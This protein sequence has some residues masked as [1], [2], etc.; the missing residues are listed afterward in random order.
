MLQTHAPFPQ[1][2]SYGLFDHERR[3]QLARILARN[4]DDGTVVISL[5]ERPDAGGNLTVPLVD[6]FD[7]T[8]LAAVEHQEMDALGRALHGK[9][10]RTKR[11]RDD[12]H[13]YEALRLRHIHADLLA[14]KLREDEQRLRARRKVA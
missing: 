4:S 14:D 13:R 5:P 10:V 11:Q 2:G 1:I 6:L 12:A 9:P 8:P 7:G 3:R